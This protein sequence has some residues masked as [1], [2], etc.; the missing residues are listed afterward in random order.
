MKWVGKISGLVLILLLTAP[1]G[2]LAEANADTPALIFSEIKVRNDTAGFDEFIELYNPGTDSVNL[3]DYFIGY[4]NTPTPTADQQFAKS[5]IGDGLLPAGARFVLAKNDADPNLPHVKKSPFSSLSDSGGTLR[6]TDTEDVLVDQFAWTSTASLA[7]APIQYQCT[8]SSATCNTN[9]AQSFGRSKDANGAYIY[10]DPTWQLGAPSPESVD[11]LPVPVPEP[12]PEPEPDPVP[13]PEPTPDPAPPA[14][15]PPVASP[16]ADIPSEAPAEAP[17]APVVTPQQ[18]PQITELL[19]NPA[20]PASDSTDEFIELYNPN[21]QSL[22]LTGYKLQ[23][24]NTFSYSHTFSGTS[25]GAHEYRAFMVTE[26]GD[27]LS[28]TSGQARLLDPADA[29]VA[30]TNAYDTANEGDAWAL[31][32]GAWQWTT[33]PTPNAPN[34]LTLPILKVAATKTTT[35]KKAAAPKVTTAKASAAKTTTGKVA[36]AKTTKPSAAAADRQVYED[37]ADAPAAIHP[38]TLAGVGVMTL[39]YAVYEYRYDAVNRVQQFRR[40]RDIRRTARAASKG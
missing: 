28:N 25:L 19:P 39:V 30:Q 13:D 38:G 3:N 27:I 26:T 1:F 11:L 6:I 20:A 2:L 40:Y 34:V 8:A 4:I 10:N 15:D 29:V 18:P 7:I 33:T 32:N 22:D 31:V 24:G 17:E 21:D 35:T 37:P 12:D 23:S 5:V 9:K 14:S 16:P 36:G